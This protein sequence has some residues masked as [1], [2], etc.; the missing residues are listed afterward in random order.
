MESKSVNLEES[1]RILIPAAWRRK[2]HL[3]EG[4]PVVLT[5]DGDSI[6]VLGTRGQA[7]HRAQSRL[8]KYVPAG[9]ILSEELIAERQREAEQERKS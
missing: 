6:T 8:R 2:M 5:F 9:R 4:S 3:R 7:L 1:G